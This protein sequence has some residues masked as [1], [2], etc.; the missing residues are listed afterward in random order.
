[1]LHDCY[2]LS[3]LCSF[4]FFI[5][6]LYSC[7]WSIVVSALNGTSLFVHAEKLLQSDLYIN[8]MM[9]STMDN[10]KRKFFWCCL[11]PCITS[12]LS[13]LSMHDSALFQHT[14]TLVLYTLSNVFRLVLFDWDVQ[15][16]LLVLF[17]SNKNVEIKKKKILW[18]TYLFQASTTAG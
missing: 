10:L 11:C 17:K 7:A 12:L 16:V 1:M 13:L 15:D 9:D 3:V 8:E 5:L 14:Q 6:P 4:S 2:M 18:T